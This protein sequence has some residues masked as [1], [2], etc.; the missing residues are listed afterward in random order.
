MSAVNHNIIPIVRN[1]YDFP[2][3]PENPYLIIAI[4]PKL[5]AVPAAIFKI[6]RTNECLYLTSSN[7][8]IK[9]TIIIDINIDKMR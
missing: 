6:K 9:F 8:V 1:K 2:W 3:I 7:S 5:E 4:I